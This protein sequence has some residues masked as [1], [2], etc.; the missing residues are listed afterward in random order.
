[1]HIKK[2]VTTL[3]PYTGKKIGKKFLQGYPSIF[4]NAITE[5][6][7]LEVAFQK[8]NFLYFGQMLG[9]GGLR[10][11]GF[12]NQV[13][14]DTGVLLAYVLQDGHPCRM[15]QNLCY[16]SQFVLLGIE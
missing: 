7:T 1:L 14:A 3:F 8:T 12:L 6:F 15:C 5:V 9:N 4:I 13:T 11:A 2:L 10:Q 16:P